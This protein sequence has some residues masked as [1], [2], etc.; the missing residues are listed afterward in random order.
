MDMLEKNT[1]GRLTANPR[2]WVRKAVLHAYYD[3][4]KRQ[5]RE[6]E[7]ERHLTSTPESYVDDS[8]TVWEDWQWV[9]QMLST[10]PPTHAPSSS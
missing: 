5:R 10:L 7:I 4:R 2:A 9:E 3:Q 1:W 6:R 8:P